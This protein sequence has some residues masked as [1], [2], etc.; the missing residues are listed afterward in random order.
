MMLVP[1]MC[2]SLH[3]L[4]CPDLLSDEL[5]QRIM[6]FR[7]R[8][9]RVVFYLQCRFDVTPF[10]SLALLIVNA[11]SNKVYVAHMRKG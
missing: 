9:R 11:A 2:L 8:C 4:S 10:L 3:I 6:N 5:F 7:S 1:Y